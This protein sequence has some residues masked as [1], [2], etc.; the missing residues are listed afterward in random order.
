MCFVCFFFFGV[1]QSGFGILFEHN[2]MLFDFFA[3]LT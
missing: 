1:L 3:L 2:K